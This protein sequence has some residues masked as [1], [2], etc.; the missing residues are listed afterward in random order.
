[1]YRWLGKLPALKGRACGERAGQHA[2]SI[3]LPV[4]SD[5]CLVK[6][7]VGKSRRLFHNRSCLII[8]RIRSHGERK[9][10]GIIIFQMFHV[11]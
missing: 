3:V 10:I 9:E 8:K 6:E 11:I 7:T 1:M 2:N 5:M 4:I